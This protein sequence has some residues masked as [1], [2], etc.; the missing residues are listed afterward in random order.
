ML[1]KHVWN[2]IERPKQAWAAIASEDWTVSGLVISVLVPLALISPI[3]GFI[4]TTQIG[5]QIGVG[6]AVK[7]TTTSALQISA[8]YF[9]AIVVAV[10]VMGALIHWMSDT[11][12]TKISYVKSVSIATYAAVP[13]FFAGFFQIYPVL[14]INFL[15]GLPALAYSVY[16]LYLGIPIIA[17]ISVERGFMFASA[18]LAV[19]L[20]ALV[21]LL[22]STVVMWSFGLGPAFLS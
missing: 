16:L 14:W 8:V 1:L 10:L 11:Y 4:G 9:G 6:G 20:V 17:N 5:W 19:A 2:I 15:F 3:A 18:I 22:A 13:L 12:S 7:L 21:G